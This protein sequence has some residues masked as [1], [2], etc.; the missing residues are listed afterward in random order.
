MPWI[1]AEIHVGDKSPGV[2]PHV[3]L[4]LLKKQ[5]RVKY[6]ETNQVFTYEVSRRRPA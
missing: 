4:E 2:D 3:V 1:D 6:N 5:E